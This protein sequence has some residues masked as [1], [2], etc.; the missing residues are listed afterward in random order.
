MMTEAQA[1]YS[2]NSRITWVKDKIENRFTKLEHSHL[3]F[4]S[5]SLH[6][7]NI[8]TLKAIIIRSYSALLNAGVFMGVLPNMP[9]LTEDVFGALS[10]IYNS[11]PYSEYFNSAPYPIYSHS[12]AELKAYLQATGFKDIN[13]IPITKKMKWSSLGAFTQ[14]VKQWLPGLNFLQQL[15][16]G[17][18]NQYLEEQIDAMLAI[19][20]QT[21]AGEISYK[22]QALYFYAKKG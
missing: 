13:I 19:T 5:Y 6:W 9:K 2:N 21:Q 18:A 4:S 3:I 7:I 17:I 20:D 8:E 11:R 12:L 14:F 10:T 22:D 1:R 15:D 16:K